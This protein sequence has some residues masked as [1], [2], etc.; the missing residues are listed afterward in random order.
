M[1]YHVEELTPLKR[2]INVKVSAEEV[3]AA[4]GATI[5]FFKKD[6]KLKGFRKGKVPSHI[7]EKMFKKDIYSQAQVDLINV[8]FNQIFNELKVEPIAGIDVDIKDKFERGKDFSY[9]FSFEVK[10]EIE[11]PEY[12]GIKVKKRK[13]KVTE[14]EVKRIL[15]RL[16]KENAKLE[17]VPEDRNPKDGD[18][19]IID[20]ET[21]ED[22]KPLDYKGKDVELALGEGESLKEFED[23][24]KSL[25][26]GEKGEGE[27]PIP[28]DFINP[29]L[30]G[31]TLLMKVHLKN[32]KERKFPT[33]EE[34]AEIYNMDSV[35]DLCETLKKGLLDF[36][37]SIERS[38]V[39]SKIL[40]ELLSKVDFPIPESLLEDHL[41]YLI[42]REKEFLERRGKRVTVSEEE[43]REK[44]K[45]T[46]EKTVKGY[47]LLLEIAKKEELTVTSEDFYKEFLK[48]AIEEGVSI[49]EVREYYEKNNLMHSLRDTI[50]INKAIEKLYEYANVEEVEDLEEEEEE[51]AEEEGKKEEITENKSQESKEPVEM[52]KEKDKTTLESK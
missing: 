21:Y 28:E 17:P 11:L 35:E 43:L 16:K 46:A 40:D 44:H 42:E 27:V 48:E 26:P 32:I 18:V 14:D 52:E 13:V 47:L 15:E 36:K 29:E 2:K 51:V 25:K 7:V 33:E 8:H 5:A 41:R 23:I 9:S 50:L 38:V 30:A 22:G 31:K 19:V 39:E 20:F 49:E 3:D 24:I 12:H 37:E 4:L 45:K 10:P 1:E 6:L 34:L